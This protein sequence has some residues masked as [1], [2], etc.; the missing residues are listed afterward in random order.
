M[1][2]TFKATEDAKAIQIDPEDPTKTVPVG[3][4]LRPK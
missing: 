2:G 1:T 4:S 3:A